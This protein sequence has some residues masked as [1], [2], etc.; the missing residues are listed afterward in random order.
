MEGAGGHLWCG[1]GAPEVI[2]EL[3]GVPGIH[4]AL[5]RLPF[6][7]LSG[8]WSKEQLVRRTALIWQWGVNGLRV[9]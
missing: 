6:G 9:G 4:H 2:W 7:G 5:S 8:V 3:L 1:E